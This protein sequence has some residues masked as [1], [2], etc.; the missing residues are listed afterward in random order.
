MHK[1]F[2]SLGKVY[3][4]GMK[5][6][7]KIFFGLLC[8]ILFVCSTSYAFPQMQVTLSGTTLEQGDT[9][10]IRLP[11]D[12]LN[13]QGMFLKQKL[14]FFQASTTKDWIS[15]VGID[16]KQ[17]EGEYIL[18]ITTRDKQ[19]YSQK[20]T[21][22]KRNFVVT[23]LP[24]TK[25][26]SAKKIATNVVSSANPAL[27]KVVKF[28]TKKAYFENGFASPLSS[29]TVVGQFGDIREN[30]YA[31]LQHLGVDLRAVEYTPVYA[32]N[33]G[34]VVFAKKLPNYGNTLVVD[35][36]L[37][38]YSMYLHLNKFKKKVGQQVQK[39]EEVA[40]SGNTGYTFGAHLH[41]SLKV[42]HASVDPLR[43]LETAKNI[44]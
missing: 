22:R 12:T 38:I 37:G 16:A 42:G 23:T 44:E 36:G 32:V 9:L 24:E 8:S 11:K 1:P 29:T 10:L 7:G 40:L 27:E 3:A 25:N 15:L 33:Y 13:P 19:K 6:F 26:Y 39:G 4:I 41:F 20:I 14:L 28:A 34:K 31:S 35:H 2:K 5:Y 17:K 30:K 18:E 21:I 43:F